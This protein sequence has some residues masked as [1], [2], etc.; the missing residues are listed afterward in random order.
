MATADL[1]L[2]EKEIYWWKSL[3]RY[4]KTRSKEFYS[5]IIV[6]AV[7]V[8]I[9]MFFIEGIMPVL[10]I[11]SIVFVAWAISKTPPVEVEHR[12][13]SWGIRTGGGLYRYSDMDFFWIEDMENQKMLRV[14]MPRRLPG[15]LAILIKADDEEKIKKIMMDQG[16][17]M[18]TPQ[19]TWMDK[20]LNWVAKKVPLEEEKK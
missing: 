14:L 13:T 9:I 5:T 17:P 3:E 20:T 6:L 8:S 16:V 18:Q 7:L 4:Q 10:V 15:M 11:W 2:N 12:I 19:K 1:D